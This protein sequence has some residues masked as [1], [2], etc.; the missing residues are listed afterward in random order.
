MNL[1]SDFSPTMRQRASSYVAQIKQQNL[2]FKSVHKNGRLRLSVMTEIQ[3]SDDYEVELLIDMESKTL[4]DS[5]CSCPV[6]DFCKHGAALAI[7]LQKAENRHVLAKYSPNSS[8]YTDMMEQQWLKTYQKLLE[9]VQKIK[10]HF[11]MIY[12]LKDEEQLR[13]KLYKTKRNKQGEIIDTD[14]YT[15]FDNIIYQRLTLAEEERQLFYPLYEINRMQR[16]Y[17]YSNI[18]EVNGLSRQ[19]FTKLIEA[20]IVYFQD[21]LKK[22][23]QWIEQPYQLHLEWVNTE[24]GQR[25]QFFLINEH[26]QQIVFSQQDYLLLNTNPIALLNKNTGLVYPV[27]CDYDYEFIRHFMTMPTLSTSTLLKLSEIEQQ[28]EQKN[29]SSQ[30]KK[31]RNRLPK[32]D[33]EHQ[34][35]DIY[36]QAT[37]I[38]NFAVDQEMANRVLPDYLLAEIIYQYPKADIY[39]YP[40]N[41]QHLI[42]YQGRNA[43]R[44]HRDLVQEQQAFQQLKNTFEGTELLSKYTKQFQINLKSDADKSLVLLPFSTFFADYIDNQQQLLQQTDWQVRIP[45]NHILNAEI[46]HSPEIS[47]VKNQEQQHLQQDGDWFDIGVKIQDK[48]GKS[49]DLIELL[50]NLIADMPYLL[51]DDFIEKL[52]PEQLLFIDN[53]PYLGLPVSIIKPILQYLKSLFNQHNK[54]VDKYDILALS[55]HE[56]ILGMAWH[57]DNKLQKFID[58]VKQGYQT[59]LP[60]PTGFNGELRHYQQQGLGW[61]QFLTDIEH[62]GILADDMGLGKTAQ[63]LAYLLLQKQAQLLEKTPALIICPTSLVYNWRLEAQKFTPDLKVLVLHG[64]ER[65]QYFNQI[66]DYDVIISSYPLLVRDEEILTQHHYHVMILDE[67]HY[68]KNPNTKMAQTARKINAKHRFCLTGTPME[69][70]LSELWSLFHFMMPAF[71]GHYKDFNK[72]YRNP[73]EKENDQ[74]LKMKLINRVKPFILRRLKTDVIQELP[75]KTTTT[76][77]IDMDTAQEKVYEAVRLT[78]QENI[79]KI[80]ADKGFNRSHIHILEALLKLRQVCCHPKLLNGENIS[81]KIKNVD[82]IPSAKFD[83][84]M[85]TVPEM[86]REGR[87]ILIFSQF[88]TMLDLIGE[89]LKQQ[90]IAWTKL[91][92]QTRKREQAIE[93]FQSGA[94]SVF[95]ISLKAG[96][97]GLNLTTADTVIHYDP[98]WNPAAENQAS[99]RAWRIGQDKPVFVYKLVT[100]QSIEQRILQLQEKKAQLAR[101]ILEQ[102]GDDIQ[103]NEEDIMNLFEKF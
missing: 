27:E 95:L 61:L 78:M 1:L 57:M 65:E 36:G 52:Y 89:G 60:T 54:S 93:Q 91:T 49:Y 76:I 45:E 17:N 59:H 64:A 92:G 2:S 67:A 30:T 84:L 11:V 98:W 48:H 88:T 37:P 20:Q 87:K 6:G 34:I 39:Y 40:N 19:H 18:L 79:R 41:Q 38:L 10:S 42:I 9:Q 47:I 44:Q 58:K 100:N 81:N 96:G 62:G 70:N 15:L 99:D 66:N 4:L 86:L 26:H 85:E 46:L 73:I 80:I 55:Q 71:L 14:P 72:N 68:I 77:H 50:S 97:V 63:T 82:K 102:S 16:S 35:E 7:F 103:F 3:G 74:I 51:D 94:V 90:G 83:Y 43:F 21:L 28:I 101:S 25:I 13:F 69:N 24:Q 5:E 33:F 31:Q 12:I 22:P 8:E 53:E 32:M 29:P 23:L 56:H 75:E